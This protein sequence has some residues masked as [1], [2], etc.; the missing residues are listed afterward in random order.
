MRKLTVREKMLMGILGV[1]VLFCIYYM[2]FF[3]PVSDR[4]EASNNEN[5]ALEEQIVLADAKVDQMKQ[6]ESELEAILSGEMGEVKELPAYDNGYN[7]MN[8]L[9]NILSVTN[10][11]NISFSGAVLEG[12]IARRNLSLDYQCDRYQSAKEVLTKIYESDYR[13]MFK[14]LYLNRSGNMGMEQYHVAVDI[15]YFEYQ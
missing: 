10:Q 6:M 15:T 9:S 11:Y 2:G 8:E 7:V 14:D 13:C 4:I 5:L 12:G 3:V 1:L